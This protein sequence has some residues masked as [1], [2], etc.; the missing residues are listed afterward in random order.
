MKAARYAAYGDPSVLTIDEVPVPEIQAGEVLIKVVATSHNPADAAIRMGALSEMLPIQLP[1]T[2][3]VDVAGTI[4][5]IADDV[6]NLTVGDQVVG[7]LP[8]HLPGAAAEYVV[9]PAE[10]L[11]AAPSSI[12][13]ADGAALPG[14]GLTAY[15]ALFELG[16]LEAGQRVLVNGAGGA[17]GSFAVQLAVGAGAE[18]IATASA[19]SAERIASYEPAQIV[20][21]TAT[22]L[23]DA[24]TEP[25]DLVVNFAPTGG[26]E[27]AG[28]V[29]PGGRV[30]SATAPVE[31]KI[32]DVTGLRMAVRSDAVQLAEL[33]R[34]VDEGK[35]TVWITD[36]LPVELITK[37]HELTGTGKYVITVA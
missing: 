19:N 4:E 36:R 17:V 9:A 20:D 11:T 31:E 14:A 7:F 26:D 18:V 27:L 33:V 10:V 29:K 1:H 32:G 28:L 5:A 23:A 13:L 2:P 8:L 3:G 37:A 35:L 22:S 12:P 16:G 15:Q 6:T 25:V 24:I 21:Y 30:V 34:L